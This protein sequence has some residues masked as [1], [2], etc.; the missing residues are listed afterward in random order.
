MSQHVTLGS[1]LTGIEAGK[2]FQTNETLA[3][4]NQLGV[5]KVSAVTWS[6]FRPD[7]AKAVVG[8]EPEEH[9]RVCCGDLLISRAN[10][11]EL[12]GAVV[13]VEKGYP[14]RLLSDKAYLLYALRSA[15]ARA[16]I[17]HFATGTSDSMRNIAQGVIASIP[18]S[19]PAL[20]EQRR[21]ADHLK[22][23]LAAVEEARQAALAQL[24]EIELLPSRL[25]AQAFNNSGEMHA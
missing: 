13:L 19:L 14:F 8:H 16:H 23:Q 6:A 22:D 21:I 3:R 4:E 20:D 12:V 18:V 1:V 5:L 17:E 15:A 7:E 24:R 11:K 10:T 9:H 2:S 25:L